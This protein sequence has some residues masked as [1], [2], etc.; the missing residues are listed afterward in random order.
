[1]QSFNKKE[2]ESYREI[3]ELINKEVESVYGGVKCV[4]G[5]EQPIIDMGGETDRIPC[6]P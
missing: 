3:K 1:M 4:E 2:F 5:I 6:F